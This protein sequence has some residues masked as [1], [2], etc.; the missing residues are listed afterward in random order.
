VRSWLLWVEWFDQQHQ[1]PKSTMAWRC[2]LLPDEAGA[3]VADAVWVRCVC[4]SITSCFL[5][6]VA[7]SNRRGSL[8]NVRR[9]SPCLRAAAPDAG[10]V[11]KGG[12]G[13]WLR[14][15]TRHFEVGVELALDWSSQRR[16]K[17]LRI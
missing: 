7:L 5:A 6:A 10:C 14:H 1:E 11:R 15:W 3:V 4:S 9:W 13:L 2:G 16:Q 12:R 17:L 8:S